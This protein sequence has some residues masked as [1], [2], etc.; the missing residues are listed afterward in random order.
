MLETSINKRTTSEDEAEQKYENIV[1]MSLRSLDLFLKYF[2]HEQSKF[3]KSNLTDNDETADAAAAKSSTS[4]S[5][6]A[7]EKI[8]KLLSEPKFW[9]YA[10]DNSL[11]IRA[12][13]FQLLYSLIDHVILNS[14]LIEMK[15][16]ES[17]VNFRRNLKSKLIPLLFYAIDE[18]NSTCSFYVWNSVLKFMKNLNGL[19]EENFWSLINVKKAFVPKLVSLLR[20]HANGNANMQNAEVIFA[21]LCPLLNNISSVYDESLD[22]KT[23]FFKD[24]LTKL[25]D[26]I[27][28]ESNVRSARFGY[29]ANRAKMMVTLFDVSSFMLDNLL[30]SHNETTQNQIFE[31]FSANISSNVRESCLC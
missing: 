3:V 1:C 19:D 18:E 4:E 21:A 22:E 12:E 15:S 27:S 6:S 7:M 14:S 23:A 8:E 13:F 5:N 30:K 10:R 2:F 31:F 16:N 17:V 9:K 25:Y 11:K 26:G 20:N 29:A 28:K 24:I